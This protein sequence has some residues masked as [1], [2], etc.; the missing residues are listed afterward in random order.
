MK[1]AKIIDKH[2]QYKFGRFEARENGV[3]I[4][5]ETYI[6]PITSKQELLLTLSFKPA[7]RKIID[8]VYSDKLIRANPVKKT[9]SYIGQKVNYKLTVGIYS[10]GR[11]ESTHS[12]T[13]SPKHFAHDAL[14]QYE[15]P[16]WESD[17]IA[18][19]FYL[20]SRNKMD[21]FG[22]KVSTMV[23]H[24]VGLSDLQSDSKESY[25]KMQDWGM[26]IF[27]VGNSLGIGSIAFYLNDK[28]VSIEK[29]DSVAVSIGSN[30]F[31][32]SGILAH[33]YGWQ[34]NK[35]KTDITAD[36]S[37][38]S[39]SRLTKVAVNTEIEVGNFVTGLAK[40]ENTDFIQSKQNTVNKWGYIALYGKQ[41]LSGD[42]LGIVV[43]YPNNK[44]VKCSEDEY[45]KLVIIKPSRKKI[46]YYF[47]A[48]WEQEKGGIKSKE[49]FIKYIDET[50]IK[51]SYPVIVNY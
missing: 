14:Y 23:M 47:A 18:Y 37:I 24:E 26:D 25:T 38:E 39:G 8:F 36:I 29:T 11:F 7:E 34:Y 35:F 9:Q 20:D 17:K 43:F 32:K 42:N 4:Y 16:G 44:L 31:Q 30:G 19:R 13:I 41:A 45:S 48:A 27:K 46:I 40:H 33:Y 1:S 21:I 51:L 3:P 15:G 50:V 10:A 6:D 22:K 28:V 12:T 2:R 5:C 49:D